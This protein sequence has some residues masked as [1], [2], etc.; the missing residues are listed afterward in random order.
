MFFKDWLFFSRAQQRGIIVLLLLTILTPALSGLA[1]RWNTHA[2]S[3]TEA[4]ISDIKRLEDHLAEIAET[5]RT[6]NK[7]QKEKINL[8]PFRFNPNTLPVEGWEEMGAPE[9]LG[10]TI[11]NYLAAGG[12]FRHKDDLQRIYTMTD[13]LYEQLAPYIDLP[14]R[15]DARSGPSGQE[16]SSGKAT[17]SAQ[18]LNEQAKNAVKAQSKASGTKQTEPDN[19]VPLTR[20]VLTVEPVLPVDI[21]RADSVALRQVPGI[22]PVFSSRIVRY[23]ELVGGFYKMDQLLEVYGM[24]SSH[25]QQIKPHLVIDTTYSLRQIDLNKATFGDMI[26]HPYLDRNQVNALLMLREQHGPFRSP[27]EIRRSHL[28]NLTDWKRLSPYITTTDSLTTEGSMNP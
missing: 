14:E 4:F 16:V 1:I 17:L 20:P 5:A 25:Y 28:I 22:G 6:L 9:S 15:G 3:D 21:N 13:D 26:R 19:D 8:K 18:N 11:R 24:D 10:R 12:Q 7:D 23:R 27:E 2:P